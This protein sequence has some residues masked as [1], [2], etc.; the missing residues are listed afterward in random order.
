MTKIL[1]GKI[2]FSN[3][4]YKRIL[5]FNDTKEKVFTYH[6]INIVTFLM[7]KSSNEGGLK[8]SNVS[9]KDINEF[10]NSKDNRYKIAK[11]VLEDL[12]TADIIILPTDDM[13]LFIEFPKPSQKMA[14]TLTECTDSVMSD[15]G[16]TYIPKALI[17]TCPKSISTYLAISTIHSKNFN[18][19]S[20][21]RLM[22]RAFISNRNYFTGFLNDLIENDFIIKFGCKGAKK[23]ANSYKVND[24]YI[25]KIA[26][27]L[28]VKKT[29]NTFF[30]EEAQ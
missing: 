7:W 18:K 3:D 2:A 20:Y 24:N 28:P 16:F 1:K 9:L 29:K 12:H 14:I 10:L 8:C 30:F 26:K 17:Q 23:E 19:I 11:K 4:L 15:K 25:E 21:T 27:Q 13:R 6:H 5:V 22:E